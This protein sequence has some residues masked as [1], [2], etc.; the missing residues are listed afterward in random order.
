MKDL[1]VESALVTLRPTHHS[2]SN[3]AFPRAFGLKSSLSMSHVHEKS[4]CPI[5]ERW[6][7]TAVFPDQRTYPH[8]LQLFVHALACSTE[9]AEIT[10]VELRTWTRHMASAEPASHA[11]AA[12]WRSKPARAYEHVFVKLQGVSAMSL[13]RS[14][15]RD[16]CGSLCR[17]VRLTLFCPSWRQLQIGGSQPQ[18]CENACAGF[19]R[20]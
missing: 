11:S 8:H 7:S 3:G 5:A 14:T 20:L 13:S 17:L 9:R 1:N 6:D 19:F 12:E 4:G 10:N 16:T 2:L 18:P 15:F